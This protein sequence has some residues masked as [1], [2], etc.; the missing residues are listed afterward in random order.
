MTEIYDAENVKTCD[1][2][3]IY[4]DPLTGV[5]YYRVTLTLRDNSQQVYIKPESFVNELLE[6]KNLAA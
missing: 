6:K 1:V 5:R 3:E 2:V 4:P